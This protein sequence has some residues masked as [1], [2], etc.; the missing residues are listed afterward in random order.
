VEEIE[1]CGK[2]G[3][4]TDAAADVVWEL[5]QELER[6]CSQRAWGRDRLG[7]MTDFTTRGMGDSIAHPPVAEF[8]EGR[9]RG[10]NSFS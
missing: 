2:D 8:T 7:K 9:G 1:M 3:A 4:L 5:I 6:W 10:L